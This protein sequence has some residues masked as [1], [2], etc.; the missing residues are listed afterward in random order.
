MDL[1]AIVLRV[2]VTLA[3]VLLLGDLPGFQFGRLF[4]S[5][6]EHFV[7]P[8]SVLVFAG[9]RLQGKLIVL[10]RDLQTVV[11]LQGEGVHGTHIGVY[12]QDRECMWGDMSST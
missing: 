2:V 11:V 7:R 6:P 1:G 9:I 4:P 12:V 8:G 3:V 5:G 10:L